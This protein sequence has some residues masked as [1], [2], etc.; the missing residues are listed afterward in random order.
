MEIISN[1]K[2]A[3]NTAEVEF[4]NSVDEFEAAVEKAFLKKRKN[5]IVPGLVAG[6]Y[7]KVY[8]VVFSVERFFYGSSMYV[9]VIAAPGFRKGKATRKMIETH[10]GEGV[11]YDD[12][13]NAL[14]REKQSPRNQTQL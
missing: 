7:L 1:N 9:A 12:A 4:K 11:F 2:T 6:G 14:Y 3:A 8:T 10:Y 5:I 13:I